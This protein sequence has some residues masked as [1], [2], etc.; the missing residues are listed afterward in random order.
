MRVIIQR[1]KQANVSI[2]GKEYAQIQ[3]G[4]MLL[5]GIKEEDTKQDIE[6]VAKKCA[7]LRIFEDD[8]HKMN[9]NILDIGGE[10]LSIS[11]FTLYA[12]CR[13]GN[14]PSFIKAAKAKQANLLYD[15]FNECLESYNIVVKTGL[16]GAFM[17]VSLMN[18]GPTTI[19]LD[20]EELI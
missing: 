9:R 14:R 15:Y 1:V 5:V 7:N 13:K 10:I 8:D 17:E 12:E 6:K 19:I 16:F 3:E 11:Q 2:E 4:F 18:D 20:S